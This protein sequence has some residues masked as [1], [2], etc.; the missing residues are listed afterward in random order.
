MLANP[1]L[2]SSAC[3]SNNT[4]GG[5]DHPLIS[6][7]RHIDAMDVTFRSGFISAYRTLLRAMATWGP[8][9]VPDLGDELTLR[10]KALECELEE[11]VT[12]VLLERASRQAEADLSEW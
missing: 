1:I 5:G 3:R 6:L 4:K 9:A 7:K 10:L 12:E 2:F 8:R 11:S